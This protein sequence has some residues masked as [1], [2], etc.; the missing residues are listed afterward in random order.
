MAHFIMI[1]GGPPII[2]Y[3]DTTAM[4]TGGRTNTTSGV[5][6]GAAYGNRYLLIGTMCILDTGTGSATNVASLTV[7]G[8]SA[9]RIAEINVR[10]AALATY[11]TQFFIV[12]LPSGTSGTIVATVN[13]ALSAG[14]SSYVKHNVWSV[15]NILSPAAADSQGDTVIASGP[16]S[17]SICTIG[18]NVPGN[19]VAAA[20]ACGLRPGGASE[21]WSGDMTARDSSTN[22]NFMWGGADYTSSSSGTLAISETVRGSAG[23]ADNCAISVSLR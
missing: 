13:A 16:S 23:G 12:S 9:T 3:I 10:S 15:R 21:V 17:P 18:L 4:V 2:D 1:D 22:S 5:P 7:A 20:C 19:G 14:G 8:Q 11:S 6:F